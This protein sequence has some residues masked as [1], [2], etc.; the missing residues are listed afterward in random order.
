M[1][2]RGGKTGDLE[3]KEGKRKERKGVQFVE[4]KIR[5]VEKTKKKELPLVVLTTHTN[6]H[7]LSSSCAQKLSFIE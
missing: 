7:L 1:I 6:T 3:G 4:R 5:K 2:R